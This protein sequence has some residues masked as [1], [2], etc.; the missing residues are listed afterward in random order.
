MAIL[1]VEKKLESETDCWYKFM[2]DKPAD[3]DNLPTSTTRG[4]LSGVK[5]YAHKTSIAYCVATARVYMLDNDDSW[6]LLAGIPESE[7]EALELK[8]ETIVQLKK[9]A[10]SIEKS[11]EEKAN[12]IEEQANKVTE[13]ADKIFALGPSAGDGISNNAKGYILTLFETAA[14]KNTAMQATYN[15][16][17]E[18]WGMGSGTTVTSSTTATLG[19]AAIG[20]IVLGTV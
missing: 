17:R 9:E 4:G 2:C 14:Y 18:E 10:E 3:I 13:I 1:V 19:K 7:L 11:I 16:L 5:K 8:A 12:T 6:R 15:A 20:K